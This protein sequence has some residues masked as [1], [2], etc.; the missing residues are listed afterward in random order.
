MSALWTNGGID[1]ATRLQLNMTGGSNFSVGL[2]TDNN[3]LAVT[4]ILSSRTETTAAGYAR[5]ALS[6]GGYAGST[7]AGLSTYTYSPAITYN[8]SSAASSPPA[9]QGYF[10]INQANTLILENTFSS[11]YTIPTAGGTLTITPTFD[12][13]KF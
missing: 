3:A 10:V 12:M 6:S 1:W 11:P 2:F 5:V 4:D 8:F 7:V 13:Q 9:L